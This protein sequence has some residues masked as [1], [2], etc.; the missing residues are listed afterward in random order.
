ME[1]PSRPAENLAPFLAVHGAMTDSG[2]EGVAM[3]VGR[4]A[5]IA[6]GYV[7]SLA[8]GVTIGVFA[9]DRYMQND[10]QVAA[11]DPTT[12]VAA[13]SAPPTDVPAPIPRRVRKV[14]KA[15]PAAEAVVVTPAIAIGDPALHA[16]VKK[17]LRPGA[18]M[19]V[20]A[21][22]FSNAEDLAATAHAAQNL[23]VPFMLLKSRV[24]DQ[25]QTLPAAI[26]ELRPEVDASD[27]AN[28]ARAAARTDIASLN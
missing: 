6:T 2:R 4:T 9:A 7:A 28:R 13:I 5:A 25:G 3:S 22:G 18:N 20:V 12:A 21:E 16:R 10:S 17:L 1:K 27:E 14:A 15:A 24:V 11:V 23:G 8:L 19:G 26:R